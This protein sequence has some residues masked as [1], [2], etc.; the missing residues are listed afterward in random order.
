M[1]INFAHLQGVW[2]E[3][4]ASFG[5]EQVTT[6]EERRN[7]LW[8]LSRVGSMSISEVESFRAGALDWLEAGM[9]VSKGNDRESAFLVE[10]A[11]RLLVLGVTG[12][13]R[14]PL[15]FFDGRLDDDCK[16][17]ALAD[18]RLMVAI[19]LRRPDLV[20]E[21]SCRRS[22]ARSETA[23][24]W[25]KILFDDT[26]AQ[27]LMVAGL[28]TARSEIRGDLGALIHDLVLG[29]APGPL[30]A[31]AS[32]RD[33]FEDPGS[34]IVAQRLRAVVSRW[35]GW[36]DESIWPVRHAVR[37]LDLLKFQLTDLVAA[38][39]GQQF[40]KLWWVE[41]ANPELLRLWPPLYGFCLARGM[42]DV[43]KGTTP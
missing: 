42:S 20:L 11:R 24:G 1:N 13:P 28:V 37:D 40:S 38:I 18:A 2:S 4:Y 43:V 25:L 5:Q 21:V 26:E 10:F 39:V 22:L 41:A 35:A 31:V 7:F 3:I 6:G 30:A 8:L 32:L 36:S 33:V 16:D 19:E 29:G 15:L 27:C 23:P 9:E 12:C 17:V 34:L 14:D